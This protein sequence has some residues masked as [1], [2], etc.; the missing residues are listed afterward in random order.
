MERGELESSALRLLAVRAR[1]RRELQVRLLRRGYDRAL[2]EQE[3]DRLQE[4]G[5]VDDA[6]FARAWVA[7]RQSNAAPRGTGMLRAEL[8]RKGVEREL[9]RDAVAEGDDPAAAIVA[10]RRRSAALAEL[11]Y[12][13]FRRRLFAHLQRRGFTYGTAREAVQEAWQELFPAA[14][15]AEDDEPIDPETE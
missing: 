5:Y 8:L 13:E 11:P 15:A 1:S 9:V 4:L 2:I 7:S 10:A 6:A 12:P 14:L 3:L